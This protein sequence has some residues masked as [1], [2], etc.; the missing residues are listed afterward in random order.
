M[1]E[2]DLLYQ[3]YQGGDFFNSVISSVV[4]DTIQLLGKNYSALIQ[5]LIT[6]GKHNFRYEDLDIAVLQD[7]YEQ[8]LNKVIYIEERDGML[9]VDIDN[10][11]LAR[12][13]AGA[14]L[15]PSVL[16]EKMVTLS[17]YRYVNQQI[18]I[19]IRKN[20]EELNTASS[21]KKTFRNIDSLIRKLLDIKICDPAMGAGVF[22]PAQLFIVYLIS[23]PL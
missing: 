5:I 4:T 13:Q 22:S 7:F 6:S 11:E 20:I 10:S 15:T 9:K 12:K 2:K 23:S 19:P 16:C 17:L 18:Q 1:K 8:S 14:F 3:K 21:R